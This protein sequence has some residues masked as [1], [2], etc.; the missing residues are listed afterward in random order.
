MRKQNADKVG[1]KAPQIGQRFFMDFG[2]M[3]ASLVDYTKSNK[4]TD[5]VVDSYDGFSAYLAIV[6]ET[7]RHIWVFLR[8]SKEPPV[9]LTS[10]FFLLHRL[11]S[12]GVVRCDQGGELARSDAFRMILLEKHHYVV[13]PT[14]ADS[15][16]QNRGVEKWNDTLLVTVRALLYGAALQPKYW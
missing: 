13:E 5:R 1:V 12:G 4:L 3:Q 8:K 9:D 16:S 7:S 2:F 15:P 10:T 14:G 6:D 11:D